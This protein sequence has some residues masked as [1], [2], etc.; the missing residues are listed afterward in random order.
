MFL[1]FLPSKRKRKGS[2]CYLLFF[3][4]LN[5]IFFFI[6]FRGDKSNISWKALSDLS[7]LYITIAG[8]FDRG[9]TLATFYK[10]LH[11]MG[12]IFLFPS[13]SFSSLVNATFQKAD[14]QATLNDAITIFRNLDVDS[15]E[16]ITFTEFKHNITF[17]SHYFISGSLRA[18][19]L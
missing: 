17:F 16:T 10:G 7:E 14:S 5:L 11:M 18:L 13:S 6:Y 1:I 8:S 19:F 15:S 9:I 2:V 4:K 3:S 12:M